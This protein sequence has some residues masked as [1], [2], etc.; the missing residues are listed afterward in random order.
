ML[1]LLIV[2]ILIPECRPASQRFRRGR[3]R[4]RSVKESG[5]WGCRLPFE[6]AVDLEDVTNV[7][8]ALVAAVLEQRTLVFTNGISALHGLIHVVGSVTVNS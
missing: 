4:V 5:F 8:I 6:V 7:V 3:G 1:H 2:S